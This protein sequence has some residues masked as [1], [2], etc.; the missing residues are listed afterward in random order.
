M[1]R[2]VFMIVESGALSEGEDALLV[3]AALTDSVGDG[4][5]GQAP[6]AYTATDLVYG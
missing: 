4:D 5:V 1:I 6:L 2:V 3:E